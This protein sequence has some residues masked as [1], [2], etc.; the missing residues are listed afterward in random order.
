MALKF[1]IEQQKAIDSHSKNIIVSAG[2]GSG[3]TAVLTERIKQI[4]LKGVKANQL[5]V[6]TFTNAAA[7][8]MK[9]R[10]TKAMVNEET[11]KNRTHEV[12]SAYITTFDSFSLSLVK[13]YHDKLNITRNIS[14]VE[15]SVLNVYKRKVL[16][17]IFTNK[18]LANDAAFENL[19]ANFTS[20]TDRLIKEELLKI[21]S[22]LDLKTNRNEYLDNFVDNTYTNEMFEDY[23]NELTVLLIEKISYIQGL[24]SKLENELDEKLYQSIIDAYKPLLIS[25]TYDEIRI[26]KK[27]KTPIIKNTTDEIKLIKEEIKKCLEDIDKL[28]PYT[29]KEEIKEGFFNSKQY[30]ITVIS[31]LKEYFDK[32]DLFKFTYEAFEFSDIAKLAIKL[33]KQFED[34]RKEL[35]DSFYEILIDEYQD[36]NDI[37]EE[38]I[39]YIAKDN[40]YMVG[41][42]K[43][44][45]YGFRNANPMIFKNKYD[46]YKNTD[47]G[48]KIDLN[49]NFRSNRPVLHTI[50]KIFNHI[51]DDN[52]G[53]ANF[54]KEHQMRFGLTDYDKES[55][56]NKIKFVNYIKDKNAIYK[57]KDID[58]FYVVKDILEK[59]KNKELVYDKDSKSFRECDYKDFAVLIAD[60]MLFEPLSLLMNYYHIP[61]NV[62]KNVEVNKGVIVTLIKNIIKLIVLDH[63][64]DYSVDF[65]HCFYSVSRS[66]LIQENEEKLF[67]AI[68]NKDFKDTYLYKLIN[69]YSNIILTTPLN[70]LLSLIIDDFNIY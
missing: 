23:V 5:L 8:E 30:A 70:E 39:S 37:Q 18:Y 35:S 16:D 64:N 1:S 7:A 40:V 61:C 66:F 17:E 52:I 31:L 27:V 12:D 38:F 65:M 57:N 55:Y 48:I 69:K 68:I 56:A 22:K 11:L 47:K 13:K 10:I 29:H 2:A 14:I 19:I 43:Q 63:Q 54:E 9:E 60:S 41:D 3:K 46:L 67:D 58:M 26:N 36:T 33:V 53:N 20:K 45:I 42:V 59:I 34:V 24:L 25:K 62:Y 44:S 49:Q 6:L 4:L 50:N 15:N 28:T 51:M 32:I 21:A